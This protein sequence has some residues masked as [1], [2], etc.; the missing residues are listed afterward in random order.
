MNSDEDIQ[1]IDSLE[2][3]GEEDP[4]DERA[5]WRRKLLQSP[6]GPIRVLPHIDGEEKQESPRVMNAMAL[7]PTRISI[8]PIADRAK[9]NGEK[10]D[11]RCFVASRQ[12]VQQR[13]YSTQDMDIEFRPG[14]SDKRSYP[15]PMQRY[16]GSRYGECKK[17]RNR[18]SKGTHEEHKNENKSLVAS[19][20]RVGGVLC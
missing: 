12:N 8:L 2:N 18:I 3:G 9:E 10:D 6:E 20:A 19:N 11:P 7:R 4:E 13:V 17:A 15:M 14:A 5:H 1:G 16:P